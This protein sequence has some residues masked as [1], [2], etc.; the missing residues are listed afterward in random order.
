MKVKADIN[1]LM[2]SKVRA[3][4]RSLWRFYRAICTF[5]ATM[6]VLSLLYGP[7]H[8]R[9]R[10]V[11]LP[12]GARLAVTEWFESDGGVVLMNGNGDIVA[13][14]D[15]GGVVWNDHYVKGWR[16]APGKD[17]IVFIYKVGDPAAIES[18]KETSK[19]YRVMLRQS[20]LENENDFLNFPG[21][22][23]LIEKLE[24]HRF[25]YE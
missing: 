25:W 13:A 4:L 6:V 20:G 7:V 14:A 5:F 8:E 23:D 16:W 17:D 3:A 22:L 12:N 21:Y 15:I 9:Y 10:Y 24:Y 18:T 11:E 1:G 2:M 19:E